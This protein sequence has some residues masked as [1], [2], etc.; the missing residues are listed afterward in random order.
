[1]KAVPGAPKPRRHHHLSREAI[2][3]AAL[4][5]I[6]REGIA[7]LSMRSLAATLRVRAM[8]L[9][10]YVEDKESILQDVVALLLSEVDLSERLGI[11]WDEVA[12]SVGQSLREMAMRHPRAFPLVALAR[13]DEPPLPEHGQ[14]LRHLFHDAGLPDELQPQLIATLDAYASGY[15]LVATQVVTKVPA[16]SDGTCKDSGLQASQV[17]N[18][19]QQYDE[20]TR[21]VISGFKERN[22]LL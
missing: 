9:Y 14:R 4:D 12:V 7:A 13:Y 1:M 22:G 2:A 11:A 5:L 17:T 18:T 6:D 10:A 19:P 20:G 16:M 21:I 15:L 3:R 8:N